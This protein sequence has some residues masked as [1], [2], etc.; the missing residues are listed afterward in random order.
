VTF[1][2]GDK[3]T[4][5]QIEDI[6]GL[7]VY[8]TVVE[9]IISSSTLQNDDELFLSVAAS[10]T[11]RFL[12]RLVYTSGTTPDIKFGFTYPTGTTATYTLLGIASG[13]ATLSAFHQNE[14]SVSA[15]EGG[16]GQACLMT[17]TW[18]TSTTAG[19]IQLQWAQNTLTA[20]N[21]QVLA[22]SFLEL[23]KFS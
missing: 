9:T 20:S 14:T 21:T 8:K 15:L 1:A 10:T 3:P 18:T 7:R 11:Y 4:A 17:G 16:T 2:A 19:V 13:G 23:V 22:G 6:R 12:A 5:A